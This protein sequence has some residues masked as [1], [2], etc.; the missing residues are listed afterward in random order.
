DILLEI[1]AHVCNGVSSTPVSVPIN[2][3]RVCTLWRA[4]MLSR[5]SLW[6]R[7]HT[8]SWPYDDLQEYDIDEPPPYTP[9]DIKLRA[10]FVSAMGRNVDLCLER[11]KTKPLD[12][13]CHLAQASP[14]NLRT[15]LGAV[16]VHSERWRQISVSVNVLPLLQL[17]R[18]K[19]PNLESATVMESYRL[20]DDIA[21]EPYPVFHPAPRLTR[22]ACGFGLNEVLLPW[23][24]L[25]EVEFRVGFFRP[26]WMDEYIPKLSCL[27][28]AVVEMHSP[29]SRSPAT[30]GSTIWPK[31][32]DALTL[33]MRPT[34]YDT[35]SDPGPFFR[36]CTFPDLAALDIE[37]RPQGLGH[38]SDNSKWSHEAFTH[39][40]YRSPMLQGNLR[41]FALRHIRI[42]LADLL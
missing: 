35:Y 29:W 33:V 13:D 25:I 17:V 15:A 5:P 2:L 40:I 8:G 14:D 37:F 7:I 20:Y 3:S 10:K 4:L 32:L 19:M 12:I 9:S 39:M 21:P 24:Q 28:R 30:E 41:V 22:R 16:M 38:R 34:N 31:T 11:S 27:R 42:P 1:F 6:S 36:E 18:G 26:R 23:A